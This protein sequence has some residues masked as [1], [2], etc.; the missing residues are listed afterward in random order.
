MTP[1]YLL[2]AGVSP[3]GR[4]L[5]H[6]VGRTTVHAAALAHLAAQRADRHHTGYVL[7]VTDTTA[8]V[9]RWGWELPAAGED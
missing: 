1:W 2:Y 9:V 5:A 7:V 3:E 6:Y 8:S 4:G